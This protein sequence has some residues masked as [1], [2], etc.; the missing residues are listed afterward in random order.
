MDDALMVGGAGEEEDASD[1][2]EGSLAVASATSSAKA[3]PCASRCSSAVCSGV[4]GSCRPAASRTWSRAAFMS[5]SETGC[6]VAWHAV[7]AGTG[8]ESVLMRA[9]VECALDKVGLGACTWCVR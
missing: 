9:A 5:A 8:F 6:V 4:G 3:S 7:C 1:A 2:R